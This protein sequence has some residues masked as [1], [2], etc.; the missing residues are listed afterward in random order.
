[1]TCPVCKKP[2]DPA[3]RPFCSRRCADVDLGRW[4]TGGYA[5]PG[6]PAEPIEPDDAPPPSPSWRH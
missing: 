4:L 5:L 6:D 2:T 3:Y 1:M